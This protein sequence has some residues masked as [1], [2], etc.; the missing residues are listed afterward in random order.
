[1]EKVFLGVTIVLALEFLA[2]VVLAVLRTKRK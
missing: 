1:M 2:V